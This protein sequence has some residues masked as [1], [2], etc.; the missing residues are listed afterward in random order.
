VSDRPPEGRAYVHRLTLTQFRNHPRLEIETRGE[1]VCLTGPNGAGKTNILEALSLLGPGRGLRGADLSDMAR[2][3]EDGGPFAVSAVFEAAGETRRIGVGLERTA[4]GDRRIARMDGR[5]A[6]P[7]DLARTVRLIWLTPAYD[8]LFAGPAGDRRRFLDRLVFAVAPEHA[9]VASGYDKALRERSRL[10]AEPR[11][12]HRWLNAVEADMAA[13]GVA[14]AAARLEAVDALQAEIDARPPSSFPKAR[15]AL[16]GGLEAI[17][18]ETPDALA[19]EE[20]FAAMLKAG[21]GR[22]AAAGRALEGPHRSDLSATHGPT[23]APAG[24][25]STGEQKA[26]V[27]GLALAQAHRIA[28]GAKSAMNAGFSAPNPVL[29]LDEAA[30]HFDVARRAALCDELAALPG[31]SWLTGT[32][33]ELFAGF[34]GK[35]AIH[36]VAAGSAR[37]LT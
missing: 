8:R 24:Q 16:E 32:D 21:R 23:G 34:Q 4:T 17:L 18:R 31:Q 1:P 12:D 28:G 37:A 5:D 25:C 33:P 36:E 3:G 9:G 13:T 35:A 27:V 10:L 15:L 6:G 2:Q 11:P 20:R 22:D 19:A 29:L 26:L 14:L 7:S 30:A